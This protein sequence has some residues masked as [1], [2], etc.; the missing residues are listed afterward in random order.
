MRTIGIVLVVFVATGCGS[1]TIALT[2]EMDSCFAVEYQAVN[3]ETAE[4]E[5]TTVDWSGL[6]TDLFG[7]DIDP[8]AD[9]DNVMAVRCDYLSFEDL[10]FETNCDEVTQADICW[11]AKY[12]PAGDE[13]S[14]LLSEFDAFGTPV[15]VDSVFNTGTFIVVA[16]NDDFEEML[17]QGIVTPTAGAEVETI[18]L[19]EEFASLVVHAEG[20]GESIPL[21]DSPTI[22]L[23]WSDWA[24]SG[25]GGGCG[26]CP[27]SGGGDEPPDVELIRLARYST[28]VTRP[29]LDM[30]AFEAR[31]ADLVYEAEV[32][33]E[34]EVYELTA[35][36]TEDGELFSSFDEQGTWM[37]GL[38][39]NYGY[40]WTP[41][42]LG[43]VG[44]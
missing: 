7:R 1:D 2:S 34:M 44:D 28:S 10:L 35:L 4:S 41:Y 13:T 39:G 27:S 38:L 15:D 36:K 18:R 12:V 31:A 8:Q 19:G 25:G 21:L 16:F 9:V 26:I 33:D 17:T 3:L 30:I 6:T 42:F 22:W 32:E 11:A 5:D 24:D 37:L 23:D 40:H 20:G 14:A 29:E 43:L